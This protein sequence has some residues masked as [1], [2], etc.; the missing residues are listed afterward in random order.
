M[1]H[2]A[3]HGTVKAWRPHQDKRGWCAFVAFNHQPAEKTTLDVAQSAFGIDFNVDRVAATEIDPFSNLLRMLHFPLLEEDI[4]SGARNA[5]RSDALTV[6]AMRAKDARKPLIAE[7]LNFT[8][9]NA[10]SQLSPKGTRMPSGLLYAKYRQLHEAKCFWVEA[11]LIRIDPVCTVTTAR[12]NTHRD[13]PEWACCC[14][15]RCRPSSAE[16]D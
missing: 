6:A 2:L 10:A 9:K 12:R 1:A 4:D 7:G 14:G 16:V 3:L 8:A 5:V 11:E 15:G 13:A